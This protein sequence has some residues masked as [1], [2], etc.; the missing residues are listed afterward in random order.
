MFK[1]I[2]GLLCCIGAPSIADA[3][4]V[5]SIVTASNGIEVTVYS[6]DFANRKEFTAPYIKVPDGQI[7]VA[8]TN[9]GDAKGVIGLT[10]FFVYSG[11]WRRYSNALFKGGDVAKFTSTGRNVGRCSSSRYSRPSCTLSESFVIDLTPAEIRAH[12]AGGMI[13]VQ[14]R[15]D[16]TSTAVFEVPMAYFK[17]I[18]E[19]AQINIDPPAPVVSPTP[20]QAPA[21]AKPVARRPAASGKRK[22]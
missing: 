7:T 8:T 6:D 13:A 15:A 19:V 18:A 9:K 22:R 3:Q 4:A 1:A 5:K 2:V 12:D 11:E 16:D 21:A 17:A 14:V 20:S 10:G